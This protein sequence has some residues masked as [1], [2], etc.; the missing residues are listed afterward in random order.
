[1]H[2]AAIVLFSSAPRSLL[3]ELE[4]ARITEI[5][6]RYWKRAANDI[7]P[8]RYRLYHGVLYCRNVTRSHGTR[9]DVIALTPTARVPTVTELQAVN[10]IITCTSAVSSFRRR[11]QTCTA[12]V[13]TRECATEC[14]D[15]THRQ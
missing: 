9:V 10:S 2:T 13:Q 1:M 3:H 4:L 7:Q 15:G 14:C 8:D 5:F 12:H 6:G 11:G